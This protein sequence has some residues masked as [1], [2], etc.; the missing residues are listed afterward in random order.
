MNLLAHM[1]ICIDDAEKY[2]Y[3]FLGQ[4]SIIGGST[5]TAGVKSVQWW[6][7]GDLKSMYL[8]KTQL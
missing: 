3:K 4:S 7:I 8:H 5:G 2:S 6:K 1:H